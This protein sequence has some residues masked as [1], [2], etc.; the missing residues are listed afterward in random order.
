[1]SLPAVSKHLKVLE[2]SGLITKERRGRQHFIRLAKNTFQNA[3]DH[4]LYYQTV[5]NKRLDSLDTYLQ[6]GST[7]MTKPR[8]TTQK[9]SDKQTLVMTHIF[10]ATPDHVWDVYTNP[11]HISEWWGPE[12]LKVLGCYND[13]R[14][15]GIWRFVFRGIEDQDYV[16]SGQ[17]QE[18]DAPH[19]LV[20]TDGFGEADSVRPEAQVTITFEP[21]S[22]GRTKLTKT[23]VATRATHQL[24]AAWLKAAEGIIEDAA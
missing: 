3:T 24:Q 7:A 23:S 18:V 12:G 11:K 15:G 2:A 19:R 21:L 10:A 17:Y 6:H 8:T 5:L 13:V 20:Y 14:I 16:V 22:D 1:M 4:L 9:K